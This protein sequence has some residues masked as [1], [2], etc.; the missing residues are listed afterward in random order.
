MNPAKAGIC[1]FLAGAAALATGR[2]LRD[3]VGPGPDDMTAA[4]RRF[5]D[6][7]GPDLRRKAQFPFADAERMN[8]NFLP[9]EYPGVTLA[10]MSAA[11][12]AA[13][14]GL[15][16]SAL[17][18]QG[19]LKVTSVF[20]LDLLLRQMSEK[21]GVPA[22]GRDPERYSFAVFGDPGSE[23]PWGWRV[24]GHHASVQFTSVTNEIVCH[25]PM[26]LGANPSEVR[27]GTASG[28]KVL[29]AEEDLA[30][31]LIKSLDADQRKR[32]L[33]SEKA[34][35][36]VALVPS[37]P[38]NF[39]KSPVGLPASS[40]TVSQR[41]TL[42]ALLDVY[43]NNL[44]PELAAAERRRISGDAIDAVH[45]AWAGGLEPGEGH[46]YRLHSDAFAIEYD[47]TQDGA[48]HIHTVWHDLAR[49]FGGDPLAEHLKHDHAP[50]NSRPAK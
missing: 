5:L 1:L 44:A 37:R 40:M 17:S 36:E 32:A 21:A 16:R 22:P 29:A 10:A 39:L 26:F 41:A 30:R 48:N 33:I 45:F 34:P 35:S 8:W 4:A 25:T 18:A 50:A 47:N 7:L 13:A 43:I 38:A 20:A 23:K 2:A 46:Y 9:G 24:Q 42:A 19:Y 6:S 27:E 12:R 3:P 14:H 11:Q 15:L 49:D 28:L 31:K